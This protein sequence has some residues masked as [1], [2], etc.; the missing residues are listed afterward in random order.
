MDTNPVANTIR[1][2]MRDNPNVTYLEPDEIARV[3]KN[4]EETAN[5]RLK[6]RDLCLLKIGFATGL[7][8][9]A[10]IQLNA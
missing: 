5:H 6:N 1:P 4:V 9:S 7:R 10:I 2:R 3:L 8:I